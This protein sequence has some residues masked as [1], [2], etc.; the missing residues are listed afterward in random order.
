[1]TKAVFLGGSLTR[2]SNASSKI[3]PWLQK[4]PYCPNAHVEENEIE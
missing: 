2:H 3:S 1:M 4:I